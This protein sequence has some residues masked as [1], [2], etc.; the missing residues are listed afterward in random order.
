ME[1]R[2]IELLHSGRGGLIRSYL[3]LQLRYFSLLVFDEAHFKV[4]GFQEVKSIFPGRIQFQGS[5]SQR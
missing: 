5:G 4:V 2:K 1:D 3:D